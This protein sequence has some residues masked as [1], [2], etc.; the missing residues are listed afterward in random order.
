VI[1][2]A[3]F[4]VHPQPG[5]LTSGTAAP[6][7]VLDTDTGSRLDVLKSASPRPVAVEFFETSCVDCQ[8]DAAAVCGLAT[9]F[10]DV[11][12]VAVDAG[13]DTAAALQAFAARYMA[14][15]CP[16]TLLVDP[17]QNV[18]H[19]YQVA[20]V[21]TVYVVDKSGKIAYGGVG[22]AGIQ[23]TAGALRTLHA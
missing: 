22:A 4:L 18:S 17:R 1:L 23:G 8:E 9:G 6:P 13:N 7:I 2:L 10:P 21:P 5:L 11:M 3:I 14:A 20:V 16:V 12:V 19:D 15:P